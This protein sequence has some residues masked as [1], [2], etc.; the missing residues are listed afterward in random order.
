M[1]PQIQKLQHRSKL[2]W[3][4][5][6]IDLAALA[7]FQSKTPDRSLAQQPKF[8]Q[9]LASEY[10]NKPY[11]DVPS[12]YARKKYDVSDGSFTVYHHN[13]DVS[14]AARQKVYAGKYL[15]IIQQ[16]GN[17]SFK[18]AAKSVSS[19]PDLKFLLELGSVD[20]IFNEAII[21][22]QQSIKSS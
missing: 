21:K 1:A 6:R 12:F 13:H 15:D 14:H 5:M 3:Q 17:E 9:T 19:N 2:L 22:S 18:N 8:W 10:I 16:H 4:E 20:K 11:L 7:P